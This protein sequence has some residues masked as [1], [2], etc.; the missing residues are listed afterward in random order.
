MSRLVDRHV[1]RELP[2]E[3]VPLESEKSPI[4]RSTQTSS[5]RPRS[6]SVSSIV[7]RSSVSRSLRFALCLML[8]ISCTRGGSSSGTT[9]PADPLPILALR[10]RAAANPNDPALQAELARAELLWPGGESPRVMPAIA[11]A[12]E[13]SPN[14]PA[15][16]VMKGWVH[17]EHGELSDALDAFVR[18]V[19]LGRTSD[20]VYA[21]LAA[22]HAIDL[23][24]GLRGGTARYDERVVPL[25]ERVVAEPGKLGQPAVQLAAHRLMQHGRRRG[26]DALV[27]RVV[28]RLGCLTSWRAVGPF[29]PYALSSFDQRVAAEGAGPLAERYDLGEGVGE[30]VSFEAEVFGCGVSLVGGE[31]RGSGSTIAETF[32]DVTEGGPHLLV[33]DTPASFKLSVDGREVAVLDRR[34]ALGPGTTHVPVELTPGRHE[35]ELK[36][37][38][39]AAPSMAVYLERP[40][41]LGAGWDPTRGVTLPEPRHELDR[42]LLALIQLVR[43]DRLGARETFT[44]M[45]REDLPAFGLELWR[46]IIN[47][48]PFMAQDRQ[49]ELGQRLVRKIAE[50]DPAGVY[51]ALDV[52]QLEQGATERSEAI[53]LVAERW[54][55]VISVQLTWANLL[56]QRDQLTEAEAVLQRVRELV[57]DDCGPIFRLQQL[58]REQNRV[59][60]ANALVERVMSC[61]QSSRAKYDLLFRQRRWDLAKAELQRLEPLMDEDDHRELRLGLALAM[62]DRD[63][64]AR[65]RAA[66][67]EDSPAV[68]SGRAMREVDLLL[69]AGR[70]P[71]AIAALDRAMESDPDIMVELR[72][73]RRDL[74]GRDDLEPFRVN[75]ADVIRRYEESGVRHDDARQV[76]VFDYMVTRVYP[77]GSARHLVHQILK[78][79]S[80]ESVEELG[81]LSLGGQIL[82]LHSIKPD[83]RR[84]EPEA[85]A[86]LDSIPMS[87]LAIGDYVEYEFVFGTS[88]RIDGGFRSAGWSFDSHDQ[89]FAFSQMIALVPADAQLVVEELGGTPPA[90]ERREGDLRVLT[91]TMEHV[92]ARP[93]EPNAAPLPPFRPTLRIA[94]KP[95]WPSFFATLREALLDR[96]LFD[97][98]ARR[99]VQGLVGER[100]DPQEIVAILHRWVTENVEPADG[101]AGYAPSMLAQKRGDRSRVLRYLLKLAGLDARLVVAR[102]FA[103]MEPGPIPRDELFT[104]SLVEVVREGA[105]SIFVWADG[106]YAS[107]SLIPPAVRGQE[108]VEVLGPGSAEARRVVIPD[109]GVESDRHVANVELAFEGDVATVAVQEIFEGLGAFVWR[110]ELEQVP[111][112]ELQRVFAEAYVPRVLP[113]AE[114]VGM[115]VIGREDYEAPFELRYVARVRGLGRVAGGQRLVPPLFPTMLA[116]GYASL[117]SRTTTQGV[118]GNAQDVTIRV[119]GVQGDVATL[120]DVQL[121]NDDVQYARRTRRDGDAVV[122]ERRLR[123]S[124]TI[125]P[126]AQYAPFAELMRRI[127]DAETSELPIGR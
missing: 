76:L 78:V 96:D 31:E 27:D 109:P 35:I 118:G 37:T 90:T 55:N 11:R 114:V 2:L 29:G 4:S 102:R 42:A 83:G 126:A 36:L 6:F 58:Y 53:R 50:L 21:V 16:F 89:P 61:D 106:R 74:T 60:E 40:G 113:G 17:E 32:V 30:D 72:H 14:D 39:R 92:P 98:D 91:W 46:R 101:F 80:E 23:L 123:L 127:T 19:E 38:M 115:E 3:S 25:L 43:G 77:D 48:D 33:I 95:S 9:P 65:V 41:R 56:Q 116:R 69:A 110:N 99:F 117:P 111:A 18:A 49:R 86:G 15:L 45:A 108:A 44:P 26:D 10:E 88:P 70:R 94:V 1:A 124:P 75:G 103:D 79:Q 85:I 63:E 97:P 105:P 73:V 52:A 87:E 112:A 68:S 12:I 20:D 22:E 82:T 66:I 51:A 125:V 54:P 84:L 47:N 104:S 59:S 122:L 71:Q 7:S 13:L 119:R 107:V 24:G 93:I 121:G 8:A 62:G 120:P 28:A 81:Q 57:P 5:S 67:E 34:A 100:T 64:E